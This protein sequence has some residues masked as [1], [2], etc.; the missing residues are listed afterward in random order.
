MRNYLNRTITVVMYLVGLLVVTGVSTAAEKSSE[1]SDQV[2]SALLKSITMNL[3]RE[4]QLRVLAQ[5]IKELDIQDKNNILETSE[6]S[7]QD[8]EVPPAYSDGI[9]A[10]KCYGT[11]KDRFA[12]GKLAKAWIK[13][14]KEIY[15]KVF[16]D[17]ESRYMRGVEYGYKKQT[18]TSLPNDFWYKL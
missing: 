17:K 3:D 10:G 1:V 18:G 14:Q 12:F 9:G 6:A 7:S 4:Q 11:N 13:I 16:P 5:T 15:K 2:V 8:G